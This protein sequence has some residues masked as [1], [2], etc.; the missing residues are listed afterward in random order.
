MIIAEKETDESIPTLDEIRIV[1][2]QFTNNNS[3]EL[4]SYNKQSAEYFPE[5][6]RKS[7]SD[8][9]ACALKGI[10]KL[11][12][13]LLKGIPKY[14]IPKLD[15]LEIP[16]MTVN[17]TLN[18]FLSIEAV[19]K[20]IKVYGFAGI[21]L[22]DFK[23]DPKSLSG[24][25]KFTIPSSFLS[26]DYSVAGQ[27]LA[28]PLK[29]QG[30]F[31]GNFT[32][33]VAHIKGSVKKVIKDGVEYFALDK[34]KVKS[35]IGD[36]YVKLISKN[37]N[38]QFA[39]DLIS[40]FYNENPRR[41]MDA[42]NPLYVETAASF[43]RQFIEYELVKYSIMTERCF[44]NVHN[45]LCEVWVCI[46]RAAYIQK[47][48]LSDPKI[49]ECLLKA[50][51]DI[52]PYIKNGVKELNFPSLN[53]FTIPLLEI[54]QGTGAVNYEVK[55]TN[56]QLFGFDDYKFEKFGYDPQKMYFDGLCYFDHIHVETDYDVAGKIL[57]VEI[58][59]KGKLVV[60]LG[61]SSG[62]L[63]ITGEIVENNN[64]KYYHPINVDA[65]IKVSN[66]T[67]NF[68]GLFSDNE[69]LAKAATQFLNEN[70]NDIANEIMP[71]VENVAANIFFKAIDSYLGSIPYKEL[72]LD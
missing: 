63:K 56:V 2:N 24:E 67:S 36:G 11:A 8:Y 1:L 53:P 52:K 20:N 3:P 16:L 50:T 68:T 58:K 65:K 60:D 32:D 54:K 40:N 18:E 57:A 21:F 39:A 46:S 26:M 41:T 7:E 5:P 13:Y 12:P 55:L 9:T 19:M 17:R 45:I 47:C 72:F 61:K 37:P 25:I 35:R 14:N 15:P 64:Q 70:A 34:F 23:A 6:C 4:M 43:F 44:I 22:N 30:F 27:L 33:G 66:Y 51:E 49:E 28:I 38:D 62:A 42:L 59:G 29:S 71:E 31:K 10:N 69:D 48:S